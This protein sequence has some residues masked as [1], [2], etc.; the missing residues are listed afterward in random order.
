M[1]TDHS[2]ASWIALIQSHRF[3]DAISKYFPD[4]VIFIEDPLNFDDKMLSTDWS[5]CLLTIAGL[6]VSASEIRLRV[7]Q[8]RSI[9]YLVPDIVRTYIGEHSLYGNGQG[10]SRR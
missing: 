5:I 3:G 7:R 8:G 10:G 9:R 1:Q 4:K 6:K 2:H